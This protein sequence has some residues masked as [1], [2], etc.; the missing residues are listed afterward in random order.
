MKMET[1][2]TLQAVIETGS[3]TKAARQLHLSPGAVS[4]Q[5]KQ[6]E[7]FMGVALLDRSQQSVQPRPVAHELVRHART[8]LQH[9]EDLRQQNSL[10]VTGTVRA[11]MLDT[12]LPVLLPPCFA[13]LRRHFPHLEL[14]VVHGRSKFLLQ[15]VQAGEIDVAVLAQPPA[16]ML[17]RGLACQHLF[18]TP[19]V[20]LAPPDSQGDVQDLLR[21]HPVIGYDRHT[22]SGAIAAQY[23]RSE[24]SIQSCDMEFDN[25]PAIISMVQL[26]LGVAVMQVVDPQW[27]TT[28]PTRILELGPHA[29]SMTY[30]LL[31]RQ[32]II[33]S[34]R[35]LAVQQGLQSGLVHRL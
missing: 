16:E 31:A 24:H 10:Q 33:D 35:I 11:G 7:A 30:V 13:Y 22:T 27:V 1:F 34:R 23:L 12:L 3:M 26:G 28:R 18:A 9:V 15:Q 2:R 8:F 25:I 5:I 32:E 20:L 29:P 19:F 21:K 17:L 6:L 14:Q 4:L